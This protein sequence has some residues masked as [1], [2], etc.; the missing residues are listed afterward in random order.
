MNGTIQSRTIKIFTNIFPQDSKLQIT[1]KKPQTYKYK[2][3]LSNPF[4]G[5]TSV[6]FFI[7]VEK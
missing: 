3:F 7:A 6:S 1:Q 5:K 4:T 2:Y